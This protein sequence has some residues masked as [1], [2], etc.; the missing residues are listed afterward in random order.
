LKCFSGYHHLTISARFILAAVSVMLRPTVPIQ[1][2]KSSN[3]AA[4]SY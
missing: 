3:N 4:A 2:E 1:A